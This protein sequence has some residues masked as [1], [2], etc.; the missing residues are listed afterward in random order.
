MHIPRKG[1]SI[2]EKMEAGQRP[3]MELLA[4]AGTVEA[5]QTAVAAGADAVYIGAPALNARALAKNFSMAEIAAMV[6]HAHGHRAKV[7]VAMNSLV[8]EEEIPAAVE[9]LAALEALAVDALIIQDLGLYWLARHHFPKLRLHAS[10][11]M[12]A[13]NSL[14]V[15]QFAAMGFQ[16]VVLARELTLGE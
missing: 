15:R 7:Y 2:G 10:T 13:H 16:R 8:K 6:D 3:V 14:A 5:F 12:T 1:K 4:P 9:T 11:L